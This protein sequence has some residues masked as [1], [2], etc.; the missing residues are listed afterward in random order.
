MINLPNGFTLMYFEKLTDYYV[1]TIQKGEDCF[2]F[3]ETTLDVIRNKVKRFAL[4]NCNL[5]K[6]EYMD[7]CN[8]P[9]TDIFVT[10]DRKDYQRAYGVL[11][12]KGYKVSCQKVENNC[13]VLTKKLAALTQNKKQI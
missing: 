9:E 12:R 1:A 13:F 8:N 3:Q 4:D 5:E 2:D 10:K 6:K 7:F 11:G